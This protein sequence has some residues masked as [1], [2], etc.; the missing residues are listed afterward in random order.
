MSVKSRYDRYIPL[1]GRVT[2][3]R[4][5]FFL[6]NL[7]DI[8]NKSRKGRDFQSSDIVL[9][10]T[11]QMENKCYS[12]RD[13]NK[14]DDEVNSEWPMFMFNFA[15]RLDNKVITVDSDNISQDK[16]LP[17]IHSLENAQS[18]S[19]NQLVWLL[20]NKIADVTDGTNAVNN[21]KASTVKRVAFHTTDRILNSLLPVNSAGASFLFENHQVPPLLAM[22][23][24][25]FSGAAGANLAANNKD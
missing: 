24:I 22:N 3:K 15:S 18:G 11:P 21:S 9:V 10:K 17:L 19:F 5:R 6:A 20:L 14:T 8:A 1:F 25:G 12:F 4:V 16:V 2:D 7:E 13:S 23:S